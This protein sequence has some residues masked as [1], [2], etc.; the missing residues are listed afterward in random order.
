MYQG[1]LF[2]IGGRI[3]TFLPEKRKIGSIMASE[4]LKESRTEEGATGVNVRTVTRREMVLALKL[5]ARDLQ[6]GGG[7]DFQVSIASRPGEQ[8]DPSSPT[9]NTLPYAL[10]PRMYGIVITG[11][12]PAQ[13]GT[14]PLYARAREREL[15]ANP[16]ASLRPFRRRGPAPT[17]A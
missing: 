2:T 8:Y 4:T 11:G 9:N 14:A 7:P 12:D 15:A 17:A 3:L 6:E 1:E 16:Q 5:A 10:G 13:G